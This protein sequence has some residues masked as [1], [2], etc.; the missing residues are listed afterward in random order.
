MGKKKGKHKK[1]RRHRR[2]ARAGE[3]DP[4]P[5]EAAALVN[6]E[7][8]KFYLLDSEVAGPGAPPDDLLTEP[9][10]EPHLRC[11]LGCLLEDM[12]ASLA[13]DIEE[14]LEDVDS[15]RLDDADSSL[16]EWLDS[17]S[18]SNN[19]EAVDPK[20][21][22]PPGARRPWLDFRGYINN[23][24]MRSYGTK[25]LTQ[26]ANIT[27][28]R[29]GEQGHYRAECL[30]WKTK[31]CF[32]H[33]RPHGCREG[34]SCSYAHDKAELRSPWH[35]KCVR[36]IKRQGQICTLGCHSNTHTFKLCPHTAAA[37]TG[38]AT[39]SARFRCSRYG[40]AQPLIAPGMAAAIKP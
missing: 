1:K 20:P 39:P 12:E 14:A 30:S 27:C 2:R 40:S 17:D 8:S 29:C 38:R 31:M 16:L 10:E 23:D 34:E 25:Q 19:A 28:F 24:V 22:D 35:V 21:D 13:Y 7:F 15:P 18:E 5:A 11:H 6:D 4:A 26:R 33:T 36:V 3:M 9:D 37:S 32:H